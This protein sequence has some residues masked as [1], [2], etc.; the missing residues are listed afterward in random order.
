MMKKN[1]IYFLL[2]CSILSFSSCEKSEDNTPISDS[3]SKEHYMPISVGNS[4]TYDSEYYG[5]Y[6]ISVTGNKEINNKE[7]YTL[8]NSLNSGTESYLCYQGN[9]LYS[10]AAIG[11]ISIELLIVDEDATEGQEW[12]AG[13]V[14]QSL[15]A[16]YSYSIK[17]TCKFVQFHETYTFNEKTYANVMEINLKTTI[18]DF[19]FGS[20]YTSLFSAEEL[21][22]LKTQFVNS[23]LQT[24][25]NQ[26][27]FYAKGIGYVNQV[28]EAM[29][30]LNIELIDYTIK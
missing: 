28:S 12:E 5:E 18:E 9:K 14:A 4:W 22:T 2:S 15:P 29:P 26:T 10:Y 3:G 27:Q 23:L 30:S 8:T 25:I 13:N 20:S 6:T 7:Y 19:E 17:Y 21:A 1:L 11:A 16:S 24:A